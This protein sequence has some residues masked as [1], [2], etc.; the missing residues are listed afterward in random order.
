MI[1]AI[2]CIQIIT[3]LPQKEQEQKKKEN[4]KKEKKKEKF[5]DYFN[6]ISFDVRL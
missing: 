1:R 4:K 5:R 2:T 3:T 6:S